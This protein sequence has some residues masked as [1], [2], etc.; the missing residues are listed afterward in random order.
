MGFFDCLLNCLWGVVEDESESYEF[1]VVVFLEFGGD[2]VSVLGEF[3]VEFLM[4]ELL[5]ELLYEEVLGGVGFGVVVVSVVPGDSDGFVSELGVVE[6]LYGFLGW[7]MFICE[8]IFL[9]FFGVFW[10][11]KKRISVFL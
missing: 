8:F 5:W 1:S 9:F 10:K 7:E 2:D 3:L 11:L 4:S 6:F